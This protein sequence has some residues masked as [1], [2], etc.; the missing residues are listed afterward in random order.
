MKRKNAECGGAAVCEA[1]QN[2]TSEQTICL[3]FDEICESKF[4][5]IELLAFSAAKR[6]Q[7]QAWSES[8]FAEQ[9]E[10]PPRHYPPKFPTTS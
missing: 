7:K 6:A 1:H 3:N 9:S 10:E 5:Q 4:K 8:N 2:L